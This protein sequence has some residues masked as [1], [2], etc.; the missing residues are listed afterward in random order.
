M[1]CNYEGDHSVIYWH[2]ASTFHSNINLQEDC[3][4]IHE[5]CYLNSSPWLPLGWSEISHTGCYQ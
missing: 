3:C 1:S 4:S 5:L 2:R